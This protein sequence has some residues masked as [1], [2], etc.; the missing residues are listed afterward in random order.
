MSKKST[1]MFV[2]ALMVLIIGVSA[3][4]AADVSTN[5]TNVATVEDTHITSHATTQAVVK[6]I[7][8]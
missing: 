7:I 4:S 6:K 2:I 1:L 8:I 3:V 5:D